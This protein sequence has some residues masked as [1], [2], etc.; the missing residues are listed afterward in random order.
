MVVVAG[1]DEGLSEVVGFIL[2]LGLLVVTMA[3][4]QVYE[5]P[6]IGRNDEI[7]HMNYIKNRF[8]DY[9]ISTDSLWINSMKTEDDEYDPITGVTLSTSMN[10]GTGE[11]MLAGERAIFPLFTPIPSA[12]SLMVDGGHGILNIHM[13]FDSGPDIDR[14]VALGI[15][16][17]SSENN[18]WINQKYFYQMGG[19]FLRQNDGAIVVR[20]DPLLSIY[21]RG[22]SAAVQVTPVNLTGAQIIGGAG[23]VKI[24]TR[25]R[26]VPQYFDET[27]TATRVELEFECEDEA[28]AV[29]WRRVINNALQREGLPSGWYSL[30]DVDAGDTSVTVI[31]YG[32]DETGSTSDVSLD[33]L[34]ADYYVT[35]Q[36][37]ATVIE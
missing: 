21:R 6:S 18:Y 24:D 14:S 19:V 34:R 2:I 10:L 9:K 13:E 16:E 37:V 8:V 35:L 7:E 17:Y 15:I 27:Q 30:S 28:E 1:R 32:P 23:P 5:V 36:N 22:D 20:V 29:V 31:I 25:L 4:Y 33:M 3:A 26:A 12:G 11:G